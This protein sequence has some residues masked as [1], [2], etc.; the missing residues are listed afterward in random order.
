MYPLF[1]GWVDFLKILD[2]TGKLTIVPN[3]SIGYAIGV[4][5]FLGC[6]TSGKFFR[7]CI[8]PSSPF[9]HPVVDPSTEQTGG[10]G[11]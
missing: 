2:S 9:F 7:K 8:R 11:V 4:R 1:N 5:H 6:V 3:C 10:V